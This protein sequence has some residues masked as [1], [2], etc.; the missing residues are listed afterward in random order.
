VVLSPPP[1]P[2]LEGGGRGAGREAGKEGGSKATASTSVMEEA[3]VKV[4]SWR[5][6]GGRSTRS[7]ALRAGRQTCR[8]PPR[9]AARSFS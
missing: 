7:L 9:W 2:V 8:M 4:R 3:R 1:P 5:T 6:V